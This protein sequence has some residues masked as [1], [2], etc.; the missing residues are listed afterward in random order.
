MSSPL[1]VDITAAVDSV[2][3]KVEAASAKLVR[4]ALEKPT[5]AIHNLLAERLLC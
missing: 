3:Y 4:T 1:P 5:E 2:G